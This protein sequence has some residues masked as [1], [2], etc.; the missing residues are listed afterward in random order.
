MK[1]RL[2][3]TIDEGLMSQAKKYASRHKTSLS[4][5]VEKYFESLTR[6]AHKK[7][8]ID[9]LNELPKPKGKVP[10]GSL[11]KRYFEDNKKKYGF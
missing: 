1:N 5:L 3:I 7:N 11:T 8:I 9:L 10:E 4:Q 2:N 6:T